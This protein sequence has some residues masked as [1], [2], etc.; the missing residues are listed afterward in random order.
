MII[1]SHAEYSNI[2]TYT[3]TDI[4]NSFNNQQQNQG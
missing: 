4:H 1:Y 2:K 3:Q